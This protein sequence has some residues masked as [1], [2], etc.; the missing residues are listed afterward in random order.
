MSIITQFVLVFLTIYSGSSL[1]CM[2][3]PKA[4][5]LSNTTFENSVEISYYVNCVV[6]ID[7]EAG[8]GFSYRISASRD[9]EKNSQLC[10]RI[11]KDDKKE[12][13]CGPELEK[14]SKS[15]KEKFT[16]RDKAGAAVGFISISSNGVQILSW[17]GGATKRQPYLQFDFA[18]VKQKW[19]LKAMDNESSEVGKG[20]LESKLCTRSASPRSKEIVDIRGKSISNSGAGCSAGLEVSNYFSNTNA[21][22]ARLE[23]VIQQLSGEAPKDAGQ[24]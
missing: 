9:P 14:L 3:M 24:R 6:G 12:E 20:V 11:D 1:A 8:S 2:E 7:L 15:N 5:R 18:D 16:L 13:F 23:E 17:K 22:S 19:N 21:D 4:I 10:L